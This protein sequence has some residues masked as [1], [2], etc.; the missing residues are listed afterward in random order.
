MAE[1]TTFDL[2]VIGG[3]PAG[4]V[5][6]IRAAQLGLQVACVEREALGGVCLNWGCIPTKALLAAAEFYEHMKHDAAEWGIFAD[7]IRHD[8]EKVIARSRG[9]TTTLNRGIEAL[10]RKHKI[11]HVAG[12]AKIAQSE[13][14]L[15]VE[16]ATDGDGE[17][18]PCRNVLIA[19]GARARA[20]PNAP[21]D[22]KRI[23]G[24]REAMTLAEQP[25]RLVV[26][27]AGAIGME[28]ACF[29]NAFGT[30][31]T[32]VEMLDR[33]L[34]NEDSDVSKVIATAC[35]SRG[36]E[37]MVATAVQSVETNEE[38]VCVHVKPVDKD[39][40]NKRNNVAKTLEADH[41]LV[42]IGVQGNVEN[43]CAPAM[44]LA[45]EKGH[46]KVDPTTYATSVECIYAAGDVIG[47]PWL[48]HV[49]SEEAI[50]CVERLAGHDAGP[51]DYKRIP[52]CTFCIPQVASVGRTEDSLR[53][54]GK[55]R[56]VDYTVGRFPFQASGKAQAV[57][58]TEGFVKILSDKHSG[59]LIGAHLV[60]DSVTELLPEIGLAVGME[61]TCK[62]I[63]STM[64]AHPTLSEA[65][66]EAALDSM[67]RAIHK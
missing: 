34:P 42:A 36:I 53:A 35:A 39:S 16:V 29:F 57:G 58:Q 41:V 37:T 52:A 17:Q 64:H 12:A 59:E 67:G 4:Y 31:V 8:W 5:G 60:G 25:K 47:P 10:L 45:L 38:G 28:L 3:G 40:G 15:V 7:N 14:G 43:L 22:G 44:E 2:V 27:G 13:G 6:A 30:H 32:V 63:I 11:H 61:A 24:A 26:V 51:I 46:I 62:E 21:F 18:L 48:A 49:A 1:A 50:V 9:V 56:K 23:I 55:K 20:L 65:L 33:V 19:T 66:H 54:E